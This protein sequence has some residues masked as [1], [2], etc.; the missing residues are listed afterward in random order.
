[1]NKSYDH[2]TAPRLLCIGGGVGQEISLIDL[3]SE[4]ARAEVSRTEGIAPTVP[5]SFAASSSLGRRQL[6]FLP[7]CRAANTL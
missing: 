7:S 6:S 5:V 2:Q 3:A 4:Y 1:M